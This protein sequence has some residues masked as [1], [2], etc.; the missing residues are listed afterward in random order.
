M[1]TNESDDKTAAKDET[2]R[3]PVP[4][5]REAEKDIACPI[6]GLRGAHEV[7]WV[8]MHEA[9]PGVTIDDVMQPGYWKNVAKLLGS[10]KNA[11]IEV[12]ARDQSWEAELRVYSVGDGFAKVRIL[13][14][15]DSSKARSKGGR[16]P[17]LPEGFK[18]DFVENGWRVRAPSGDI[19]VERQATKDDAISAA[20]V[21][22]RKM[23]GN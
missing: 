20:N 17:V 12:I 14:L 22:H 6:S 19:I 4:S 13:N 5:V 15:W 18:A 3:R 23:M 11:K 16:P 21:I 9:A 10:S 1:Q 7:R 2:P 8:F